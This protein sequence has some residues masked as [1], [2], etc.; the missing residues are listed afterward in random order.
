MI[1]LVREPVI[2]NLIGNLCGWETMANLRYRFPFG[3]GNNALRTTTI[4]HK[5]SFRNAV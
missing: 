5:P 2:P 3:D 1:A 4:M